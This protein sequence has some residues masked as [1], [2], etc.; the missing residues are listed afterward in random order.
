MRVKKCIAAA[1]VAVIAS[2]GFAGGAKAVPQSN[3]SAYAVVG[4]SGMTGS[5]ANQGATPDANTTNDAWDAFY[6]GT[7]LFIADGA[8]NRVLI[9]DSL[10]T[11]SNDSAD[12]VVGQQNMTAN[13]ANQ[14]GGVNP[15]AR[16]LNN[17]SGV[18][19]DGTK[20]FISDHTNHRVLIYNTIPTTD[21]AAANVVIG[22]PDM[23]H[24]NMN[25]GGAASAKSFNYPDGIYVSGSKLF[26]ADQNNSRVLIFNTVPT[27][28]YQSAS[29]VVG[30]TGMTGSTANQGGPVGANTL[31]A[32][33]AVYSDGTKLLISD[34]N[35]NR[36]LV[37]NSIPAS[38]NA[39]ANAAIGQANLNSN[40]ANQGG[41]SPGANTLRSPWGL[42]SLDDHLLVG[43]SA[44]GRVLVFDSIPTASNASA[45]GVV[46]KAI[47]TNGTPSS[48]AANT[49]SGLQ[50]IS[51][52]GSKLVVADRNYNRVML[53]K[54]KP[55]LAEVSGPGTTTDS[56]PN[57]TFSSDEAGT[58]SYSGDCSSSTTAAAAGNNTI[59]FSTLSEGVHS[60]CSLEVTNGAGFASEC[61]AVS[62][63]TID[64]GE[65]SPSPSPSPSDDDISMSPA[66]LAYS[67]KKN[68]KIT[69]TITVSD[70]N[71][72]R[73]SKKSWVTVRIGGRKMKTSSVKNSGA[74]L[75]VKFRLKYGRW[76]RASYD[77]AMTYKN[78][79]GKTWERGSFAKDDALTIL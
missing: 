64:A 43:D 41:A 7:R 13:L 5:N 30:Q 4:Q 73:K 70:F 67:T 28:D 58:I 48:A 19:S 22:Q 25:A 15:T 40:T 50:G 39:S 45:T 65:E 27:S 6:D 12:V 21:N 57:F 77:L 66:T 59:T 63:I 16:T 3:G 9:Y 54:L 71:L 61:L 46:G 20:L 55:T 49:L 26:V 74:N 1:M 56:T 42:S 60:N 36:V 32:P 44:N 47:F 76:A 29:F 33:S 79:V 51:A 69:A 72:A 14:G 68:R 17:P 31:N 23:T 53:Y 78:K 10:P 2:F 37:F 11:S 62:P 34:Y 52:Y 38:N 35:N 18:Y 75:R 8:N 24:G